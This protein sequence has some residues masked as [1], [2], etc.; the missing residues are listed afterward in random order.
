MIAR[1]ADTSYFLALLIPNDENHAAAV[2]LSAWT[3]PL[4]TTDWVL[5]ETGNFLAP[6]QSRRIFT[7]FVRAMVAEPRIT[8]VP[9]S[10]KILQRG[11]E[12][13]ES[14]PDKDW[15]LTDCTS[16]IVMSDKGIA[17]A[18]SADHH[19]E[20]AGFTILLNDRIQA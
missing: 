5:V 2:R 20:Q 19:F 8:V 18:L 15:S 16:F 11:L 4:V 6:Q 14:R 3:G 9:A 7:Q 10:L 12:L 1:F 17:D 13:Y